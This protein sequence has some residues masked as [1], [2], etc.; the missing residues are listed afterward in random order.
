MHRS[1]VLRIR[2]NDPRPGARPVRERARLIT[3]RRDGSCGR[4]LRR[5]RSPA[6]R[7]APASRRPG[8]AAGRPA[9]GCRR[10]ALRIARLPALSSTAACSS[11][12]KPHGRRQRRHQPPSS[13]AAPRGKKLLFGSNTISTLGTAIS[14]AGGEGKRGQRLGIRRRGRCSQ[15]DG[16]GGGVGNGSGRGTAVRSGRP[17]HSWQPR[18]RSRSAG[19]AMPITGDRSNGATR[20][21][22]RLDGV[23]SISSTSLPC[24]AVRAA[25]GARD[26]RIGETPAGRRRWAGFGIWIPG[27]GSVPAAAVAA[28]GALAARPVRPP[29]GPAPGSAVPVQS[30][31][32]GRRRPTRSRAARARRTGGPRRW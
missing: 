28:R 2:R 21:A 12:S 29:P 14:S 9:T 1:R 19:T 13:A 8:P 3:T 15:G 27:A 5:T 26:R 4:R 18:R 17:R 16:R 23:G 24:A 11:N 6:S 10:A 31:P 25:G 20:P 22:P 32:A 7:A 30:S